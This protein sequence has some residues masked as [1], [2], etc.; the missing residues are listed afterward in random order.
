MPICAKENKSLHIFVK[1][2]IEFDL[3][4]FYGDFISPFLWRKVASSYITNKT[5]LKYYFRHYVY[6]LFML[7][8]DTI[9]NVLKLKEKGRIK[10]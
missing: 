3:L 9:E 5:V 7:F 10:N 1:K 2:R 6:F 4:R 8:K